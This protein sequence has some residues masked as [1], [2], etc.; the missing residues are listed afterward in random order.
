MMVCTRLLHCHDSTYIA[1]GFLTF[2]S[3]PRAQSRRHQ[4]ARVR[5]L[6][7]TI[8]ERSAMKLSQEIS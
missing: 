1:A 6:D 4:P 3:D 5:D 7:Q 2:V 8:L